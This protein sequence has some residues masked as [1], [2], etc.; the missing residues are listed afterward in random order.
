MTVTMSSSL[1]SKDPRD[2]NVHLGLDENHKKPTNY[3]LESSQLDLILP[4]TNSWISSSLL[5]GIFTNLGSFVGMENRQ[6]TG[7]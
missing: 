4:K 6:A 3:T 1:F 7:G 5:P 2:K